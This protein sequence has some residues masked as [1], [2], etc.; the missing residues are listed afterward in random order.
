[1]STIV[2]LGCTVTVDR[3]YLDGWVNNSQDPQNNTLRLKTIPKK[4][5]LRL[6]SIIIL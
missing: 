2:L 4:S 6:T 1:M 5:Y 3:G